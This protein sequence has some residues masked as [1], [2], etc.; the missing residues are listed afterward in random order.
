[1]PPHPICVP[2]LHASKTANVE[3]VQGE[4]F[5]DGPVFLKSGVDLLGTF[6]ED[7]PFQT[8]FIIHVDGTP[9]GVDGV[10]NADEVTDVLVRTSRGR[11]QRCLPSF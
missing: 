11:T 4:Y 10:V 5:L 8:E 1:M 3:L 6:S 7:S 9:I 2:F